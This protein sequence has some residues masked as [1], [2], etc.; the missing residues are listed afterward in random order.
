MAWFLIVSLNVQA[1][2]NACVISGSGDQ[3]DDRQDC[4]Q[5]GGSEDETQYNPVC[6]TNR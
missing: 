2:N 3:R 4:L 6:T 1:V 5:C